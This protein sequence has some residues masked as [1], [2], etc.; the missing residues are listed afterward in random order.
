MGAYQTFLEGSWGSP[1]RG[2]LGEMESL[3][4]YIVDT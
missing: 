3:D 1:L 2:S 4:C